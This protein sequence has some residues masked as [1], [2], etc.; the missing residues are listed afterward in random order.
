MSAERIQSNESAAVDPLGK[1]IFG[2][3][4]NFLI[5][6]P[7]SFDATIPGTRSPF[8]V[9]QS[10]FG[11]Y[12]QD[13][14]RIRPNLTLNL[15]LRYEM[16]TVPTEKYNHLATL[17]KLT[18]TT[19]TVGSLNF[20]NPTLRNFSPRVGFAWDPFKDGKTSM[21]GGFGIY[22]TL[23]LTYQFTLLVVNVNPFSRTGAI[24]TLPVGSFPL[25]GFSRLTSNA[26]TYAYVQ[27][28]PKRS[29]VEQW[30][31]S[32]ER[33]LFAHIVTHVGYSGEHGVHQPF[34]TQDANSVTPTVTAQGLIYPMRSATGAATGTVVNPGVGQIN[35][36]AWLASN[37]YHGLNV[38]VT[39]RQKGLRLGVSYTWSKSLDNSSASMT[40]GTFLNGIPGPLLLFPQYM[41]GLSDFDVRHN[42]VF[43]YLWEIPGSKSA[44]NLKWATNGWQ[45]GGIYRAA[46]GLPFTPVIG[47]DPL[48][49]RN[50]NP[51]DFP[52]RVNSPECKNP[53]NPGNADHYIRTECFVVPTPGSATVP[54]TQAPRLGNAG[55]NSVIGPGISN[56][57]LSLIKNTKIG[58]RLNVQFRSEFFNV[59]NHPNFQVPD[60]TSAQLFNQSLQRISTAGRLIAT[61]TTSRQIQFALKLL[62]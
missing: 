11:A 1:F 40:G 24:T 52:D 16:A 21:R 27:P 2:S 3:L 26:S 8:Y 29:Y 55:R 51:F 6:Q 18:D 12:A 4:R 43:N 45:L 30:S 46:S 7:A 57:D 53:V 23:P 39:R 60:R 48:G 28:N 50:L 37:T 15:G 35:S 14:Y 33:Q 58:E 31:L 41:R 56:F 32:I 9:R 10:I 44:K 17:V 20:S 13:D 49:Q 22:D 19:P 38:A 34:R 59:L 42:F 47:G 36:L 54:P 5:N 25:G 61:S 62:F